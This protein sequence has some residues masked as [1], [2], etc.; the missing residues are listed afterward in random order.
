MSNGVQ[1]DFPQADVNRLFDAMKR[2]ANELNKDNGSA[3]KQAVGY[4][5]RSLSA[6]TKISAKLRPI[7]KNP[8]KKWKTDRRIAPFGVMKYKKG[9]QYFVP[10]YRTGEYGKL[11]FFD[12]K[13]A[14][15]F[16]RR[17]GKWEKIPSGQDIANPE[18]IVPGIMNDKR[19]KIGNRGLAKLTWKLAAKNLNQRLDGMTF[20]S[21]KSAITAKIAAQNIETKSNFKG[22]DVFVEIHNSLPYIRSA[23]KD[24]FG[25]VFD[26]A[27]RAFEYNIERQLEKR[28]GSVKL[29]R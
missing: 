9:N 16:D 27:A 20:G 14:S 4:L 13:S 7:V 12:K 24:D 21:I 1:F 29:S 28:F 25:S 2:S 11:R 19:R 8:N 17:S 22:N 15:W 18:I 5:V 23:I 3:M 6:S 10:I 26:R